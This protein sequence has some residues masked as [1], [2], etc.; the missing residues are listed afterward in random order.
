[1][2][3]IFPS[4]SLRPL[5]VPGTGTPDYPLKIEVP[6]YPEIPFGSDTRIETR[7]ADS[8][9]LVDE[10]IARSSMAYRSA[11][12]DL[13][14]MG[15]V[16]TPSGVSTPSATKLNSSSSSIFSQQWP[17]SIALQEMASP[18]RENKACQRY[19]THECFICIHIS[20]FHIFIYV[21]NH[22]YIYVCICVYMCM[23][24][25]AY[26]FVFLM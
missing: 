22:T 14:D 25:Y 18:P 19:C 20:C 6:Y 21:Y 8:R 3:S 15:P 7:P 5:H 4:N 24:T 1:M 16:R 11:E 2:Q 12:Y 10:M 26:T 23:C 13:E 17:G 9:A